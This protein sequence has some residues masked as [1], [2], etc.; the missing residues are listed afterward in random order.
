MALETASY[1]SQ[2]NPANPP[3]SDPLANAADHIRMIK[4]TL[5]NTFPTL[6]SPITATFENLN[7]GT[8]VGIISMWSGVMGGI[9]PGWALC[10]GAIAPRSDGTGTIVTPDLQDRFVVGAGRLYTYGAWGGNNTATLTVANMPSHTHTA[11]TDAQGDHSHTGYT[12]TGGEHQHVSP[13]GE[14]AGQYQPP[15]GLY[16]S[17]LPGS[18]S[19]DYDNSWALT[20]PAGTH[21]HDIQTYNSGPHAHNTTIGAA[22]SG[23]AFDIRPLYYALAF[24]MKV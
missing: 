8:P 19:T 4:A 20:S 15:W 6:T 23:T 2:L 12:S 18:H 3:G 1:I 14:N 22:G 11:V 5:K 16:G 9:P 21:Y 13:W 10:N 17:G 7:N 24:I